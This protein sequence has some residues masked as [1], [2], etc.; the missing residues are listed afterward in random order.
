MPKLPKRFRLYLMDPL[1]RYLELLAYLEPEQTSWLDK[2]YT[3]IPGYVRTII[4]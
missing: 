1:P 4:R 2:L 3:Q